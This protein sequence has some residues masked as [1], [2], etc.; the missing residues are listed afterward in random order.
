MTHSTRMTLPSPRKSETVKYGYSLF[1]LLGAYL[2]YHKGISNTELALLGLLV[3]FAL[4]AGL[5]DYFRQS[6]WFQQW[7]NRWF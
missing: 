3:L 1:L 5:L 6:P 7:L 2:L 4:L